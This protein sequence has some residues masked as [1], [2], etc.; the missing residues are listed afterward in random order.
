VWAGFSQRRKGAKFAKILLKAAQFLSG[1][2]N[3]D[4]GGFFFGTAPAAIVEPEPG[5]AAI[6]TRGYPAGRRTV[7][8]KIVFLKA[9]LL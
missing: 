5:R 4:Q 6:S 1:G 9:R 3:D 8:Q 2:R 7:C